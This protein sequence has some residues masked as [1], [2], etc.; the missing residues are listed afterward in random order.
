MGDGDGVAVEIEFAHGADEG[1]GIAFDP[2]GE[3]D[4]VEAERGEGGVVD[5]RREA[6]GDGVGDDAEDA[7]RAADAVDAV[8]VEHVGEGE[9]TGS[10]FRLRASRGF[11]SFIPG[12]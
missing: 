3:I 7:R 8:E 9:L 4:G 11:T 2:E 6:V 12:L 10:G 5:A 1:G